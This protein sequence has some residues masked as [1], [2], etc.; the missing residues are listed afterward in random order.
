MI[1]SQLIILI[2]FIGLVSCNGDQQQIANVSSETKGD[3]LSNKTLVDFT[4]Q[5]DTVHT[6]VKANVP[7]DTLQF[8]KVIAY[9]FDGSVHG[10]QSLIDRDNDDF[11]PVIRNQKALNQAQVNYLTEFLTDNKTYGNSNAFCFEPH[12]AFVFYK[13]NKKQ[14]LIDVC[15][16]CNFLTSTTE[17]PATVFTKIK[18]GDEY[19]YGAKGFS[20]KGKNNIIE[21]SR[22]LE[23][24]YGKRK[25]E[26]TPVDWT[27]SYVY[28]FGLDQE[29]INQ[30][31]IHDGFNKTSWT[32][33]IDSTQRSGT[34]EIYE[35]HWPNKYNIT[36][37]L[38]KDTISINFKNRI[39]KTIVPDY[40]KNAE[41][42][43]YESILKMYRNND[44]IITIWN[45]KIERARAFKARSDNEKDKQIY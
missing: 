23:L 15:L 4:L 33:K 32:I 6:N 45:K 9:D 2:T 7:F 14:Y 31:L 28:W 11:V 30:K 24:D 3:Y 36:T 41:I 38:I 12:M 19:E 5:A 21:I 42:D 25:K 39:S 17:I 40:L 26:Q 13:N 37:T 18:I 16:D 35:P 20:L 22:Q 8:D 29:R 1:K 44:S 10:Y 43:K 34:L 27:G